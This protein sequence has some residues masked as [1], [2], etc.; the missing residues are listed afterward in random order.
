MDAAGLLAAVAPSRTLH[1]HQTSALDGLAANLA[2]GARR[3]WVVLPPGAGK[4]LVGVEAARRLGRPVVAFGPNT[5]I[6]GQWLAE[7]NLLGPV[8]PPSSTDRDLRAVFTA[9]TYQALATFDPDAEVDPDGG[10][11]L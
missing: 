1:P 2:D 4:T 11:R 5:A 9:L 7:W 8:P 6:Q 10:Q 3:A